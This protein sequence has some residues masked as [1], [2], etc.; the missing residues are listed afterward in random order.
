MATP[1]QI[2][3]KINPKLYASNGKELLKKYG[4]AEKIP[5]EEVKPRSTVSSENGPSA[6]HLIRYTSSIE[7]MEPLYFWVLDFMS[8]RLGLEVEKLYDN[9]TSSPGSGHFGEFQQ[10][11]SIMQQQGTKLL[12]DINTVLRSVMNIIYDL[13]EFKIRLSHYG[14]LKSSDK[15]TRDASRLALKQIWMDRV[16]MQKGAGSINAMTTGQLGFQ[17]LRD[18]FLAVEDESL[19][20]KGKE[21]DLNDKVKRILKP[22]IYEFNMWVR[23]SESELKKRY[24]LERNYLKSQVNSLKI[25]SRWVKPYLRT[26]AQLEQ[27]E[28]GRNAALVKSFN[29][30]YLELTLLAKKAVEPLKEYGMDKK[31]K[32][33]RKYYKCVLV[34][35]IFRGIPQKFAQRGDYVFGG[36]TN[37]SFKAYALNEDEI[38]KLQKELEKSDVNE[39]FQ[40]IEGA[41]EESLKKMQEEIDYFL[42]EK[43][44]EE[45]KEKKKDTSN[46]FLAMFGVYN[47]KEENKKTEKKDVDDKIK[48]DDWFEANQMRKYAA[49]QA[50]RSSYKVFEVYKK[51]HGMASF[52][53]RP[54]F[55]N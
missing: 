44:D 15:A 3:G 43:E 50:I 27:K 23:E 40:L 26:S 42:D 30:I 18:A 24:E 53:A 52:D 10:R 34:D 47:K 7:Q 12:A 19:K 13:K 49:E 25:Y 55:D 5:V 6:E 20:L 54:P 32:I 35:F 28:Q 45:E 14:G 11:A 21:I 16:D 36:K 41:T 2:I 17:T 9:F 22:R 4:S 8:D 48:P 38:N 33:K 37:I 46:P 51:I 39:L 31:R 29:T 1:E